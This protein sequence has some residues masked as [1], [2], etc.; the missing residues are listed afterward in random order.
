MASEHIKH[1]VLR[2]RMDNATLQLLERARQYVDLDRSK[3]IRQSIRE[4]ADAVIAQHEQTT[5]FSAED[6]Q[7]FFALIDNPPEPTERLKKAAAL[8]KEIT[9]KHDF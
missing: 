9:T 4:K 2:I 1:D 5:C 6:W 8:Y 7:R 3:F